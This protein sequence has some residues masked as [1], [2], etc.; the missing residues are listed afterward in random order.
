[1]LQHGKYKAEICDVD[2]PIPVYGE[3]LSEIYTENWSKLVNEFIH[4]DLD[5]ATNKIIIVSR[6]A[7]NA[8]EGRRAYLNQFIDKPDVFLFMSKMLACYCPISLPGRKNKE[9]FCRWIIV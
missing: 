4:K 1:M 9:E 8:L 3:D 2:W 5:L 6:F 7:V